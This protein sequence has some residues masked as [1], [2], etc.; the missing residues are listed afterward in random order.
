MSTLV[1][2]MVWGIGWWLGLVLMSLQ[3]SEPEWLEIMFISAFLWP[4]M[5]PWMLAVEIHKRV[6]P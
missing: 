1:V 2:F 6:R 5:V 3:R 4:L